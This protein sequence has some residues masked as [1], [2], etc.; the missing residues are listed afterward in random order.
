M[1]STRI[2]SPSASKRRRFVRLSLVVAALALI[3]AACTPEVVHTQTLIQNTRAA[4][5]RGELGIN[6]ELYFKA[7]G[8]ADK[9]A[10]EQRLSHSYLP[11]GNTQP[12]RKLAENVG[13]GSNLDSIHNNFMASSAHKANIIDP[14]FNQLGVGVTRDGAGRYWVVHEFMQL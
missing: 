10:A 5:G 1:S 14:A 8:W 2:G 3:F 13:V 11:A 4:Y 7:Q 12:W 9:M 6:L